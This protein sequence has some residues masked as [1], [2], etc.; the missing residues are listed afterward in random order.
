[1]T[2]IKRKLI[3]LSLILVALSVLVVPV[4]AYSKEEDYN[5]DVLFQTYGSWNTANNRAVES[6]YGLAYRCM[7]VFRYTDIDTSADVY[8]IQIDYNGVTPGY[9]PC[10]ESLG[11][12]YRWGTSGPWIWLSW[13]D[14][15]LYDGFI[16]IADATSTTCEVLL[17][18]CSTLLDPYQ[19]TWYFGDEPNVWAYWN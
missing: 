19:N 6:F 12:Y 9:Y 7:I 8:K 14:I 16:T 10:C 3:T 5:Y 18:D 11:L 2:R 1:M 15:N 13:L 17:L 4:S